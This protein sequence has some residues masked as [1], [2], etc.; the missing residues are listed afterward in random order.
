M[1]NDYA[2]RRLEISHN[3]M[4][5]SPVDLNTMNKVFCS[6]W[7]SELEVVFGTKCNKLMV[8]NIDTK[9]FDQKPLLQGRETNVLNGP[10][11]GI[12]SVKINP[13]R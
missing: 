5:E 6:Q 4:K 9:N 3:G 13:S 2:W 10:A 1:N 11:A 12:H 8:Y 7:L